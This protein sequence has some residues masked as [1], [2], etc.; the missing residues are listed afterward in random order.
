MTA[1]WWNDL[2]ATWNMAWDQWDRGATDR[3]AAAR[4][5]VLAT[6]GLAGGAEARTVVLRDVDRGARR[7]TVFTDAASGKVAELAADPKATLL[8]WD[9]ANGLQMRARL[10]MRLAGPDLDRWSRMHG[11]ARAVYGGD[12][13]PGTRIGQPEDWQGMPDPARFMVLEGTLEVLETLHVGDRQQRRA[14]FAAED[15]WRGGWL[16]P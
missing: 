5:P 11:G 13:A 8:V 9:A 2:G 16:A 14:R 6:A 3:D 7:L 10:T 4:H 1:D 12:P 15:G